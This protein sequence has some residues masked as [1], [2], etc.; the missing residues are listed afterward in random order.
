M[1]RLK[2]YDW[3]RAAQSNQTSNDDL[4]KCLAPQLVEPSHQRGPSA[5]G[6]DILLLGIYDDWCALSTCEALVPLCC[7]CAVLV[8][9]LHCS[10]ACG[11]R[12]ACLLLVRHRWQ[13]SPHCPRVCRAMP[14]RGHSRRPLWR[15][16]QTEA[17]Q[18]PGQRRALDVA[19]QTLHLA[20]NAIR[21]S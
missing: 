20:R 21:L 3:R 16:R 19:A 7:R 1:R 14:V 6:H 13:L 4:H 17:G 15:H 18:Q 10:H 2:L 9:T 8:L 11:R 12:D 5:D